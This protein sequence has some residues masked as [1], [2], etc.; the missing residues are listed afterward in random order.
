MRFAF[1]LVVF[2]M[3]VCVANGHSDDEAWNDYKVLYNMPKED[4]AFFLNCRFVNFLK[5]CRSYQWFPVTTRK[6]LHE[7]LR[8][9]TARQRAQGTFSG[10]K[11]RSSSTQQRGF[12]VLHSRA[13]QILRH[14]NMQLKWKN[15]IV[16]HDLS[17]SIHPRSLK[18]IKVAIRKV[19]ISRPQIFQGAFHSVY[20]IHSKILS[21]IE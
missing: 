12:T 6:R 7:L 5:M 3:S 18:M 20:E 16:H 10:S 9:R 1:Q 21:V 15:L 11:C 13:Q 4:F 19:Q 2:A 17:S 8:R 14:G